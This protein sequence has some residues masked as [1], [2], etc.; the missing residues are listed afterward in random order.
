M[1]HDGSEVKFPRT[2]MRMPGTE[3]WNQEALVKVGWT[4]YDLHQP[5]GPEV[6][7]R[8]KTDEKV[9]NPKELISMARHV[10]I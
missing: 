8:E 6:I 5:R 4:P 3:K 10:Y 9:E 1:L 7:F 2:V